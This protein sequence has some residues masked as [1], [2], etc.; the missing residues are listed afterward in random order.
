MKQP[1]F[2]KHFFKFASG[3]LLI[4]VLAVVL[5]VILGISENIF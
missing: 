2:S 4:I 1:L 5:A 3:F